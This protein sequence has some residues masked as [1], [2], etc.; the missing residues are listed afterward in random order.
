MFVEADPR[1][2]PKT[3]AT[4]S[5]DHAT[6]LSTTTIAASLM[7]PVPAAI[8]EVSAFAAAQFSS[9]TVKL[10]GAVLDWYTKQELANATLP[11]VG[12]T[13]QLGDAT[14]GANVAIAG[15]AIL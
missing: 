2:F 1:E 9:A 13:Y 5:A 15:T 14:S 10:V 3:S 11:V 4:M 7:T 12:A 6:V 8:D